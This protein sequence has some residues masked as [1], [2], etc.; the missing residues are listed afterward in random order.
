MV[1]IICDRCGKDIP[2]GIKIGY[3]AMHFKESPDGEPMHGNPLE[4]RHFCISCMDEIYGFIEYGIVITRTKSV[5]EAAENA[6]E[7]VKTDREPRKRGTI[8]YGKIMALKNAGWDNARIADEMG[9]TRTNVAYAVCRYRKMH[10]G[11]AKEKKASV[12]GTEAKN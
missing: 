6:A 7:A 12:C 8:D 9:M 2:D 11:G 10:G 5:P 1:K 4:P 3:I